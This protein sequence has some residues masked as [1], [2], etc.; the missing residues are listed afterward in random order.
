VQ[1]P[2]ALVGGF[3]LSFLGIQYLV[4]IVSVLLI[5]AT[6]PLYLSEDNYRTEGLSVKQVFKNH[7]IKHYLVFATH[8]IDNIL[9]NFVWP[10]F[11]FFM[12]LKSYTILG[13]VVSLTALFSIVADGLIGRMVDWS[14]EKMLRI[15]A[16]VNSVIW[17]IK[18]TI[19]TNLGVYVL[20]SLNGLSQQSILTSFGAK[21]YDIA[22][23]SDPVGFL[24]FR[25]IMIH[26]GRLFLYA[27]LYFLALSSWTYTFLAGA[28]IYFIYFLF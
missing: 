13:F 6:L 21:S 1:L 23:K 18:T 27:G 5:A 19:R 22:E 28:L 16:V 15:G 2:A 25:E 10:I 9:N 14:R 17:I 24:V 7:P 3:I 8:G 26:F 20:D 11:V 4:G 12:I